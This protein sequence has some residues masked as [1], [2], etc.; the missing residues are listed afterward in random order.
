MISIFY[1][2]KLNWVDESHEFTHF[3]EQVHYFEDMSKCSENC[4]GVKGS[5]ARHV[6]YWGKNRG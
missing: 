5:L 6:T 1:V 2:T 4:Q 3:L